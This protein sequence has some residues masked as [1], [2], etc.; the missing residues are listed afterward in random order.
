MR[1]QF[2]STSFSNKGRNC[3][4]VS[5]DTLPTGFNP[6]PS[7]T[8]EEIRDAFQLT[9]AGECFNPLP[10]QTKEETSGLWSEMFRIISVSIHFLFKQR[11]KLS[12]RIMIDS[13]PG[14]SIHFLFKQRKKQ[15]PHFGT[16]FIETFQS[17]SFS[18]KGRNCIQ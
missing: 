6:L 2:Q 12:A 5:D 11:K 16:E 17:T 9:L 8:K 3:A 10:F 14:V 1:I 15:C 18:N 4:N 13:I 7:Q